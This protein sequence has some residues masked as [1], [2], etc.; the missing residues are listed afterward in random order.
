MAWFNDTTAKKAKV[1]DA[2]LS[3]PAY[4]PESGLYQLLRERLMKL[5]LDTLEGLR[6]LIKLKVNDAVYQATHQEDTEV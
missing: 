1:V 6:E 5:S 4:T 2:I 3:N